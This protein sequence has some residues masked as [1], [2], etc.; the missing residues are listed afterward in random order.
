MNK[1]DIG[2]YGLGVM[3]RNLALNFEENGCNVSVYNRRTKGEEYVVRDFIEEEG[4]DGKNIYGANNIASFIA[5]LKTPRKIL[6]MVQAGNPVDLVIR[7]L[8]PFLESGDIIIDGGNSNFKDTNRRVDELNEHHV[9]FVGMGVSGGEEGA[10]HGPSMMPGGNQKAWNSIQPILEASAAKAFDGSPC[11]AWI[12][13]GGAGHFVKMV[14]NG[15]EYADMQLIAETYHLMKYSLG[16]SSSEIAEQFRL[17]NKTE[18]DSYLIEI[19]E[20]ILLTSDEDGQPLVDKILDCAGQ[21]GTGKWTAITALELGVP[22]PGITQ[23]VFARFVSSFKQLRKDLA[24]NHSTP[25]RQISGNREKLLESLADALLASRMVSYAE[26]FHLIQGMSDE[27]GWEINPAEVARIWQ[28]G[29]IIRSRLLNDIADA[30]NSTTSLP[31]LFLD[32]NY[33]KKLT[34]LQKG[35]RLVVAETI[36]TGIPAPNMMAALAFFDSLR[37][38]QLP[39]NIIQ[40][41]RD[42]FG[43]HTY[44]RTDK[45]RGEF[46]HTDWKK[47]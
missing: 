42:Y 19:T 31:H 33:M 30:F 3:G 25:A 28:G 14:H 22:L 15:I 32:D 46:F 34:G 6:L 16:M 11:C 47:N 13:H 12:G 18:L 10:R 37:T 44:E 40:A 4:G 2:L 26:G 35:W 29:C 43:A 39:A 41:Q 1:A 20:D 27:S 9:L 7:E 5:S 17:W 24:K 45:P 23:S 36:K 8:L 21:K 38:E